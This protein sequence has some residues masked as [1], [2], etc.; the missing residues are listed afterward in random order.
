M[1][2][3]GTAKDS[4]A[5]LRNWRK[6]IMAG[7]YGEKDSLIHDKA[8]DADGNENIQSYEGQFKNFSI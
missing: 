4:G 8:G 6:I 2:R 1:W 5:H 3:A 7:I